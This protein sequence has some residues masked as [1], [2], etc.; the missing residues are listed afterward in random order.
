M[1]SVEKKVATYY[2]IKYIFPLIFHLI[3]IALV[4]WLVHYFDWVDW[5]IYIPIGYALLHFIMFFIIRPSVYVRVTKFDF[6]ENVFIVKKGFIFVKSE[7]IPI[8]RIQEI[9]HF[10][11]PISRRFQLATLTIETASQ[12]MVTPPL[13]YE[14]LLKTQSDL[15]DLVKEDE[16]HA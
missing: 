7:M 11:G 5:I 9:A 12:A 16:A 10:S 4:M 3:I 6:N 2:R 13:N 15:L 8:S 14:Y 1:K